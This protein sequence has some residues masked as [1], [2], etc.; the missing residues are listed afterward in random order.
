MVTKLKG[1]PKTEEIQVVQVKR[2][3]VTFCVLGSTPLLYHRLAQKASRELLLPSPKKN[4]NERET[5]LKHD[6]FREYRDSV[7][8]TSDPKSPTLLMLPAMA[9]KCALRNAAVD[10]PGSATKAAIGR[11]AYVQ[12]D[13]VHVYGV[14]KIHT[15][16]VRMADMARTPDVRTRACLPQW[17]CKLTINYVKP[18]LNENVV[19]NLLAGAGIMQGVGDFR[20][21]KG[22][23]NYGCFELVDEDDERFQAMLAFGRKQ[24]V[25]AMNDPECYDDE[26]AELLGW[27]SKE[28][29]RREFKMSEELI[30]NDEEIRALRK[31]IK[32]VD[33]EIAELSDE[34]SESGV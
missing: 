20:T 10:I 30:G 33:R 32:E 14:P 23:G 24:Q 34:L 28:A 5:T 12:G 7:H 4:R 3:S 26:T 6:P 31:Q 18:I 1:P 16:I 9:F 8:A 17:A 27:F 19:A 25:A 21:E 22:K 13:S 15:T 2:G 11:L 29:K